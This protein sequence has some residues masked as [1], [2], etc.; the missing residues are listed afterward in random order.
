MGRGYDPETYPTPAERLKAVTD[1]L[2]AG[3]SD[4]FQSER[5][6]EYLRTM[7]KFHHYSFGNVL[8]IAMQFPGASHV[9]GLHDWRKKFGRRVKKGE[10]GIKILAPCSFAATLE[11]EKLDP[12]TRLPVLDQNGTPAVERVPYDAKRFC[13]V[14]VFDISQTEGEAL[15]NIVSELDGS[16][17]RYEEIS[18]ALEK[19]SPY[20]FQFEDLPGEAKGCCI[21]NEQRIIIRPGMSEAQTLKTKIHEVAH[22]KLHA[23]PIGDGFFGDTPMEV[24][25]EREV[26]AESVAYVVCQHFGVDTSDYSFGYIA[27]WSHGKELAELKSSLDLIRNTAAELIDGIEGREPERPKPPPRR[28][29]SKQKRPKKV[30]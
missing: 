17:G 15:P 2:E 7:S 28:R 1:Q 22:A 27:G 12:V 26:E 4:V 10:K 24:R 6:E 21:Y 5:Y 20:P 9:A 30:R 18:A 19:L 14:T 29:V 11:I 16:V 23:E 3:V 8:L 13:V 25:R